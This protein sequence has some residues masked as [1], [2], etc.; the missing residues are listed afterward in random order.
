MST[1]TSTSNHPVPSHLRLLENNLREAESK[2]RLLRREVKKERGRYTHFLL[3][4]R[5]GHQHKSKSNLERQNKPRCPDCGEELV[6]SYKQQG[7]L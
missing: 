6:W 5:N 7:P 3:V 2:A 4:C 1:S